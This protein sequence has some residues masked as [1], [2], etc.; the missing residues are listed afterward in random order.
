MRRAAVDVVLLLGAFLAGTLVAELL[1][2][3]NLGRAMTAG[4]VAFAIV[5]VTILLVRRP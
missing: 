3:S 5:L 4:Q 1:G 2:A